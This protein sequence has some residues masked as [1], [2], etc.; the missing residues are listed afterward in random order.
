MVGVMAWLTWHGMNDLSTS[1]NALYRIHADLCH[2]GITRMY[3][4]VR[5]RNLPYSLENVK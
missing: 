4:Y 5:L 2:P 1:D 3:H